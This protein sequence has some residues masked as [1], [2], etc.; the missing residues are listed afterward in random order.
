VT[1]V[2]AVHEDV[3]Q[4]A[5]EKRQPDERT[6]DMGAVL[7]EEQ[8]AGNDEEAQQNESRR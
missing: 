7:G 6:Q 3:H 2:P 4:R 5:Q 8:R 1:T